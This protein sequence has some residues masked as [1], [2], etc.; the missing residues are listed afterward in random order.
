[1]ASP[2]NIRELRYLSGTTANTAYTAASNAAWAAGTAT[3]LRTTA[4]DDSGLEYSSEK[5]AT[6]ET[7]LFA[8]RAPVPTLRKGSFSFSTYLGAAEADTSANPVATLLSKIMGG[9]AS[10]TARTYTADDGAG[11]HTTTSVLDD[12]SGMETEVEGSAILVGTRGDGRGNAEVRRISDNATTDQL[13]VDMAWAGA[14]Q[15]GDAI[16]VATTV[17]PDPDAAQQYLDFLAIGHATAD[18]R[19]MLACMAT[20]VSLEGAAPG[21]LPQ[22]NYT[23]GVSDWQWVASGDRDQLEPTSAPQGNNPPVD[24]GLA[25]LYLGD[26]GST[27]RNVFCGANVSI[28]RIGPSYVEVP[29]L[30][31]L[32]GQKGYAKV[33]GDGWECSFDLLFD[34]DMTGLYDDFSAGTAKQLMIQFGHAAQGCVA[35]DFPYCYLT[36]DPKPSEL[37]GLSAVTITVRGQNTTNTSNDLTLAPFKI[38]FF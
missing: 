8:N 20:E 23:I 22:L 33:P 30:N 36:M 28:P 25:G 15:D 12:S 2:K 34:E 37:N 10:P 26:A 5:D 35:L 24:R 31:G 9:I 14:P 4:Y 29:C 6:L 3:K 32:N 17:Y 16:V 11:S 21:E 27:T 7:R 1:M 38:H 13:D 19:Q 18:Q